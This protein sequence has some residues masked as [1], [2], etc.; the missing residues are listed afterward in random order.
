MTTAE[1]EQATRILQLVVELHPRSNFARDWGYALKIEHSLIRCW[2]RKT[3]T[4]C[5]FDFPG[6]MPSYGNCPRRYWNEAEKIL[7]MGIV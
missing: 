6:I 1:L 7:G 4:R 2:V 5:Y 3:V